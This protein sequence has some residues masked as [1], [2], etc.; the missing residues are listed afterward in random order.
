[1]KVF[2]S[3]FL[4]ILLV[5]CGT[6][7]KFNQTCMNCTSSQR[8]DPDEYSPSTLIIDGKCVVSI[9]ETGEILFI[10][11]ILESELIVKTEGIPIAIAKYNGV[12]YLIGQEFKNLWLIYGKPDNRA[13]ICSMETPILQPQSPYFYFVNDNLVL[14]DH[15]TGTCFKYNNNTE[16]WSKHYNCLGE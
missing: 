6:T 12:Y 13:S 10:D 15:E 14:G 5:S 8:I 2:I 16:D 4:L 9:I 7:I 3:I 1:M 11:D